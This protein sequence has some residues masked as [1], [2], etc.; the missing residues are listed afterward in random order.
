MTNARQQ[1]RNAMP[2]CAA[3]WDAAVKAF[4]KDV[5]LEY[6][7]EGGEVY[8]KR[9]ADFGYTVKPPKRSGRTCWWS[10]T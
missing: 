8:G 1:R 9:P 6:A 4:G 7:E 3:F 5:K 2:E 10:E